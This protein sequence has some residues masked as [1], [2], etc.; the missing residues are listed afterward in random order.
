MRIRLVPLAAGVIFAAVRPLAAQ[1][2]DGTPPPCAAARRA[3]ARVTIP[4]A[5]DRARRFLVLPF[6]NITR[7]AEQEWLVEGSPIL[8]ADA[9]GRWQDLSVVSDER[10]YPALRRQG[11][12]PGTVMEVAKV[13]RV[14]EETNGWTAVT[15]EVMNIGG[16]VR[17]S[18]RAYDVVTNRELVRTTAETQ[19]GEDVRR[20]YSR[21]S[22]RLLGAA[23]LDTT[24]T[25]LDALTTASLEAYRAYLRGVSHLRRSQVKQARDAMLE[26]VR[27]DSNFAQ[28]YMRLAEASL[29]IKPDDILDLTSPSMRYMARAFALA[30]RLPPR[31]RDLMRACND[32]VHGRF[33]A[34]RTALT[35]LVE[36]DSTDVDALEWLASLEANDPI[37]VP[38]AGGERPRGSI[39]TSLR[40]L[41]RSLELDP[42]RHSVY[43]DLVLYHAIAGGYGF[44]RARGL[45]REPP[46]IGAMIIGT[47]DRWFAYVL[48]DTVTL[49]PAESL[50]TVPDDTLAAAR[51][52]AL[53]IAMQWARRWRQEAPD[54]ADAHLW[55]SRV[56]DMQGQTDS[57]LVALLRA[58]SLGVQT[59]VENVAV[60][61]IALL[62]RLGRT[63]QARVI[64]DSLWAAGDFTPFS[65]RTRLDAVVEVLR[66]QLGEARYDRADTLFVG[67]VN[68]LAAQVP[69]DVA[70]IAALGIVSGGNEAT[71]FGSA[72]TGSVVE[73]ILAAM[74]RSPPTGRPARWL[75]PYVGVTARGV[76][77]DTARMRD[78]ILGAARDL[79]AAGQL[80]LGHHLAVGLDSLGRTIIEREP[81]FR[82][83][84]DSIR[85]LDAA[86]AAR[87]QP[88]PAVVYPDSAVFEW[89]V[90]G[91]DSVAWNRDAS[92][93]TRTEYLWRINVAG[94]S[95]T[96]E[97]S[98]LITPGERQGPLAE[99]LRGTARMAI[100]TLRRRDAGGVQARLTTQAQI[101][102]ETSAGRLRIV[103][104]TPRFLEALR[105]QRPAEA[106]VRFEPCAREG[107]GPFRCPDQTVG[108][109]YQ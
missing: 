71:Q 79:A 34:A 30:D 42:A 96:V 63:A 43:G 39:N 51:S 15:G 92:S 18:A 29:S 81:W 33:S 20:A 101:R 87:F 46:S 38:V 6:R 103:V 57:A 65:Q 108:V 12:Q 16:R 13:R 106:K 17:V 47:P 23:G 84:R 31:K 77:P 66:I 73:A 58:D 32:L 67:F 24:V 72:P 4:D 50:S 69:R 105:T 28:A 75:P 93:A 89:T 5:D 64:A 41:K 68:Q 74:R 40:L 88:S 109:T 70:E 76:G 78:L 91:G 55:L 10:L 99:L 95:V 3:A 97:S 100:D 21:I 27:L 8:L 80:T 25:D 9:I 85:A 86:T 104:R 62:R 35:R 94:W 2:P 1:C 37:L 36:T 82:A 49:V 98:A 45:R 54:E 14:A 19:P 48:R 7:G 61:R 102:A 26:A 11:L 56:F 53:D 59:G 22:S 90:S 60:R 52:R 83:R 107:D 44:G